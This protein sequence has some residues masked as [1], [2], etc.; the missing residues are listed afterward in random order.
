METPAVYHSSP[1][2]GHPSFSFGV[3]A[4]IP[5]LYCTAMKN[6]TYIYM[7]IHTHILRC[8]VYDS[9]KAE[10]S[11]RWP[12]DAPYIWCPEKFRDHL[13]TPTASF[14]EIFN[15]HLFRSILRM[16]LQNLKFAAL[17]VP[18]IIAIEVLVLH[19][20]NLGEEEARG[21]YCSKERRWVPIGPLW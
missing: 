19:T 10:L 4:N 21:W 16:C 5:L 15:E 18:E 14:P 8:S 9:K 13:S 7:Y 6:R 3:T 2:S 1:I 20:P 17:S 12:R 11:Q